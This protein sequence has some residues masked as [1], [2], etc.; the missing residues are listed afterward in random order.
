MR[1]INDFVSLKSNQ[2][3]QL[4]VL[5]IE[6]SLWLLDFEF[7]YD[8]FIL[9]S[10]KVISKIIR[11]SFYFIY[12]LMILHIFKHYKI[13]QGILLLLNNLPYV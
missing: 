11:V 12:Y 13:F 1:E 3:Y 10:L 5:W 9:L 2:L 8:I 6:E 4:F 7:Y